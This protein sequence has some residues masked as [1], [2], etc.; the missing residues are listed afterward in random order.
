MMGLEKKNRRNFR[1]WGGAKN[2]HFLSLFRGCASH[3]SSRAGGVEE[4]RQALSLQPNLLFLILLMPNS[5]T[6]LFL[7]HLKN[8]Q[9][10]TDSL[11]MV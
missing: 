6:E 8:H 1:G 2:L 5:P 9:H 11:K 10:V 3:S 7:E 4:G